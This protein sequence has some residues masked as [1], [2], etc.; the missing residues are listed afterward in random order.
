[1]NVLGRV[2]RRLRAY[3]DARSGDVATRIH[4]AGRYRAED[5]Q[6]LCDTYFKYGAAP[7]TPW[8]LLRDAHM[9]LPDWFRHDLDPL[10]VAYREQQQRLWQTVSGVERS[11]DAE[12]DEREDQLGEIDPV[13]TPGYYLRRD[14]HAIAAASDHVLATGMFLKHCG[15]KA[16]D[17]ALEYGPGFGQTALALARM[18]VQVDTVDISA[19]FCSHMQRQA[20]FYQVPLTPFQGR[21][22]MNPRPGQTYDVIWFYESFHHCLDFQEVVHRLREHLA[23]GGRVILGGEPIPKRE[24]AAVPYPWGVRLHSEVAAVMRKLHWFELGFSER[25]LNELFTAA[26]FVGRR[27]DC[28]PSLF[29]ELYVFERRPAEIHLGRYWL[30]EVMAER[31]QEPEAEGRRAQ[32]GESRLPVDV[33]GAHSAIELD[34]SNPRW[35][36][37]RIEAA[38]GS[39]RQAVTL[40]P[41]QRATLRFDAPP[42]DRELMLRCTALLPSLT[43]WLLR[44]GR[45]RSGVLIRRLRYLPVTMMS[46]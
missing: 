34:V 4:G 12:V 19:T 18:G 44:R 13:R 45:R 43:D 9:Q 5:I 27:I 17:R 46:R 23:E 8:D 35:Y 3:L 14:A 16:G 6:W 20:D 28:E 31:W 10:S 32:P 29:G 7:G 30:P 2:S 15:L 38:L 22:G 33:T 37:Q 36:P 21:F 40:A 25:F 39:R 11:Y 1:V 26:G 41:R 42:G 24:N